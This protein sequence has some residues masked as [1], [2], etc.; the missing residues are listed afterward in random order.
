MWT[1]TL[2]GLILY[3]L[4]IFGI[5]QVGAISEPAWKILEQ[6]PPLFIVALVAYYMYR[7]QREENRT[8]REWLEKMLA[9]QHETLKEAY[10]SRDAI[11]SSIIA[12][13]E[14]KQNRMDNNIELLSQQLAVNT[15]TV[16]EIAKVDAIVSD[17]IARLEKK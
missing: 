14:I 12:Q 1:K 3:Q 6:Y 13:I 11:I 4:T 16:S 2:F 15:S 5:F 7:M 10:N 9:V 8:N 17:L